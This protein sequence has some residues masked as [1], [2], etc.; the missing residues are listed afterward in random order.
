M[1]NV[2]VFNAKEMSVQQHEKRFFF[3]IFQPCILDWF[4]DPQRPFLFLDHLVQMSR[5]RPACGGDYQSQTLFVIY[6]DLKRGRISL[7]TME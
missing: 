3:F 4:W 1:S 5:N 7:Y 2:K 6:H